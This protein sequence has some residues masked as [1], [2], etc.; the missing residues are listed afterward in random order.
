MVEDV[1]T[2]RELSATP[3]ADEC[4]APVAFLIVTPLVPAK[5][6]EVLCI[7]QYYHDGSLDFR[8]LVVPERLRGYYCFEQAS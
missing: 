2:Q 5:S 1:I 8:T 4:L 3:K 7:P 6:E